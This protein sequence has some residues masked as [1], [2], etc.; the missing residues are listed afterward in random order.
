MKAPLLSTLHPSSTQRKETG[1]GFILWII[2]GALAGWI[3]GNVMKGGGFGLLGNIGVGI[4]GSLIGGFV[5]GLL[6]IGTGGF[7]GSLVTAVIG[8]IILLYVVGLIRR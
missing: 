8:A 6:G 5:F 1:M 2:I 7:I 3:A 4:V